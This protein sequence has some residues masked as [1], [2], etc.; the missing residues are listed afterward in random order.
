ME[1]PKLRQRRYLVMSAILGI[2]ALLLAA[3]GSAN[4]ASAGTPLQQLP[5]KGA[6]ANIG[7]P[8]AQQKGTGNRTAKPVV[9]SPNNAPQTKLP[10]V[11]APNVVLYDQLNNPGTVS[12]LSQEFESAN[13]AFNS[14][15]A[16]NFVV[17]GGQ[18]WQITE[19]DAQ[20]VY[21]NG[22]GPAA[23]FNVYFYTSIVS[24]TYTIPGVAV[25]TATGQSYV[26]SAGVFQ[27]TLSSPPTLTSGTY[28][29]SA[30]ARMDFTPGGEWGWTDRTVEANGPAAWRN[31]GGGFGNACT[32][33][34]RRFCCT[35]SPAA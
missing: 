12:T 19:V 21:F 17:P 22:P 6:L 31:P 4:R 16:D 18:S 33:W 29:V 13:A 27:V 35:R 34:D 7:G 24:G 9:T 30:Q 14:Q 26:N 10:P 20:A 11:V 3:A 1:T 23:S 5:G 2:A 25:Y 32:G 28:F 15:T 8:I